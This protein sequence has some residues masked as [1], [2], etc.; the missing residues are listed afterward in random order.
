MLR[1]KYTEGSTRMKRS[2]AYIHVHVHHVHVY[3]KRKSYFEYIVALL[4]S[5][6]CDLNACAQPQLR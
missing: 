1:C 5:T 6:A 2:A 4:G 3:I